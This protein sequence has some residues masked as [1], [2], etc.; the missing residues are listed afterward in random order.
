MP[1]DILTMAQPV[2]LFEK[3]GVTGFAIFCIVYLARKI[4]M[5]D[6]NT[7]RSIDSSNTAN[8]HAIESFK[9]AIDASTRSFLSTQ[10]ASEEHQAILMDALA[11]EAE[12]RRLLSDELIEVSRDR[13]QLVVEL[14]EASKERKELADQVHDLTKQVSIFAVENK[15]LKE[16]VAR[17]TAANRELTQRMA[18]FTDMMDRRVRDDGPPDGHERRTVAS[19]G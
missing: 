11:K 16:E 12:H 14:A 15:T 13:R 7:R 6:A 5:N 10:K 2:T 9:A 4:A 19:Q 18:L 17:L 1:A 8:S 3:L